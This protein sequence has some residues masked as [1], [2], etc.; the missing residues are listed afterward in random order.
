MALALFTGDDDVPSLIDWSAARRLLITMDPRG[1]S[2]HRVIGLDGV[3]EAAVCIAGL[4]TEAG[5]RS[6]SLRPLVDPPGPFG[7]DG[8]LMF[9]PFR[10]TDP[11]PERVALREFERR[12][13]KRYY[14]FLL[15]QHYRYAATCEITAVGIEAPGSCAELYS[16]DAASVDEAKALDAGNQPTPDILAIYAEC[17][18]FIVPGSHRQVWLVPL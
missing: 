17:K 5:S 3:S 4:D 6:L 7:V 14:D 12:I 16:I 11:D 2:T 1:G 15:A 8:L 18:R 9:S 13:G 10:E